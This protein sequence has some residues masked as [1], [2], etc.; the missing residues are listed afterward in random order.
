[1]KHILTILIFLLTTTLFAQ[2]KTTQQ[3]ETI[4]QF[5]TDEYPKNEPGAV[6]LISKGDKILFQKAYGLASLAPKRKLKTDMVFRIASMTKQFTSAAVLQLVEQGKVSLIDT[7]QQ[8]V[9]YYPVKQYPITIHHLLSQTSGIPDYFDVDE[10]EYH[11]LAKEYTPK[12]MIAYFKDEPLLFE[13]GSK[14]AY[15]NSNYSL[16]N[17]VIEKASGMK[18]RIYME[19]FI[20]GPLEMTSS[21]IGDP[22]NVKKRRLVTGYAEDVPGVF[23]EGPAMSKSVGGVRS[24]VYDLFLWHRAL[25]D[26]TVISEY[27]VSQLT[28]EKQINSGEGTGYGYGFFLKELQGSPTIQHGG[29]LFGFTTNGLYLPEEDLFVCVLSNTK[30]DRTPEIADY[31]GSV[32]MDTPILIKKKSEI[33]RD[34][35]KEYIGVYHLNDD[36]KKRFGIELFDTML[37]MVPLDARENAGVLRPISDDYF[38]CKE[39]K[40]TVTFTR[41]EAEEIIGYTVEQDGTYHFVKVE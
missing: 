37:V 32:M 6:V 19:Q 25:H 26:K 11:L 20:F 24:T 18:K 7:I 27:V 22:G 21:A 41:N 1:M 15:S 2:Q 8:Y 4:D 38:D 36:P 31:I 40:A 10:D 14:W 28:T 23:K 12:D 39:A 34:V 9:P 3:L 29:N 13:P 17:A 5:L 33:K 16:L 35:Y 30:F